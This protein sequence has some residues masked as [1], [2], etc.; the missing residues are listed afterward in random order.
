MTDFF[1]QHTTRL[2][3]LL[4]VSWLILSKAIPKGFLLIVVLKDIHCISFFIVIIFAIKIIRNMLSFSIEKTIYQLPN[5]IIII[6]KQISVEKQQKNINALNR[7]ET[8]KNFKIFINHL[9][10]FYKQ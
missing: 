1:C 5:T 3:S 9:Q 4:R 10:I 6:H 7:N 2:V 8:V